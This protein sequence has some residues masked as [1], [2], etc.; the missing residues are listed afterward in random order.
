MRT[1]PRSIGKHE[2]IESALPIQWFFPQ[3][4]LTM[5][6]RKQVEHVKKGKNGASIFDFSE[7]R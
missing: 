2:S 7:I 5:Q 4:M 1:T 6:Y 3:S